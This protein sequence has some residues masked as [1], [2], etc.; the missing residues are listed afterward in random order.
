MI[1]ALEAKRMAAMFAAVAEP[2]RVQILHHLTTGPL[3]VGR[4]AELVGIPIVNMSHHLGVMRQAGVLDDTKNGRRVVYSIRKDIR[5]P[6]DDDHYAVLFFGHYR[7]GLRR[8]PSPI[9][10]PPPKSKKTKKA[11]T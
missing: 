6:E 9:P 8:N 2:T 11:T 4:L 3:H 1:D 5:Q 10:A 7:V